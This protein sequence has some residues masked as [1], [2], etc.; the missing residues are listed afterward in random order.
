MTPSCEGMLDALRLGIM[1]R[2]LLAIR[3]PSRPLAEARKTLL[4]L[5]MAA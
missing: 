4:E 5:E 3:L 1:S 2:R